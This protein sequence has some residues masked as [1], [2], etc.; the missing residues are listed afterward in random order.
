MSDHQRS[1][2]QTKNKRIDVNSK[3]FNKFTCVILMFGY[4]NIDQQ[5]LSR[6]KGY[7]EK[8]EALP[9]SPACHRHEKAHGKGR[10]ITEGQTI[11]DLLAWG[12]S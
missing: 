4:C 3:I 6:I 9:A 7:C 11:K 8:V 10:P 12:Q 1:T 2:H 5:Y